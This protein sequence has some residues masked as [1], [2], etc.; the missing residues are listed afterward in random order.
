MIVMMLQTFFQM[1]LSFI[2]II[3]YGLY[4]IGGEVTS[5]VFSIMFMILW[6]NEF[7]NFNGLATDYIQ[8]SYP[9][10]NAKWAA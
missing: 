1:F 8:P 2:L 4:D 3:H 10:S 5:I 9:T 7:F 6:V